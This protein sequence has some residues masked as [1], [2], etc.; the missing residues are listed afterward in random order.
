[1]RAFVCVSECLLCVCVCVCEREREFP[2]LLS[3]EVQAEQRR[4]E[5]HESKYLGGDM[6]HTHLVKGLDYALLQKVYIRVNSTTCMYIQYI[7]IHELCNSTQLYTAHTCMF[8]CPG[9]TICVYL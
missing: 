3:R 2:A 7:H 4:M 8:N 1:M 6:E 5:I 9:Y